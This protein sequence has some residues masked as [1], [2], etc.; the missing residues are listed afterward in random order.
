MRGAEHRS[1]TRGDATRSRADGHYRRRGDECTVLDRAL[2]KGA[3]SAETRFDL[4]NLGG[5]HQLS[6]RGELGRGERSVDTRP[7]ASPHPYVCSHHLKREECSS[8]ASSSK[9]TTIT[10]R[11]FLSL[12]LDVFGG[13]CF[14][15]MWPQ[16]QSGVVTRSPLRWSFSDP[17]CC[18][19]PSSRT[20]R[21]SRSSSLTV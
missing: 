18:G 10:S 21:R 16:P 1:R 8:N 20:C 12:T 7:R 13:L 3:V 15:G 4:R 17:N 14:Q 9:P 11:L 19:W 6:A 5:H 2:D